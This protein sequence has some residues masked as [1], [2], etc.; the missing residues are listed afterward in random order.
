MSMMTEHLGSGHLQRE[1]AAK[2]LVHTEVEVDTQDH[3]DHTFAGVMFDVKARGAIPIEYLEVKSIYVRGELGP[4]T[5]WITEE[6][7]QG[8]HES[9]EYWTCIHEQTH[10]ASFT[11]LRELPF[12]SPVRL[13]PGQQVGLY[14]H[15]KTEGDSQVVYDNQRQIN[16]ND[17]SR[18]WDE[19]IYVLPGMAHL[20]NV[21]FSR[22]GTEGMHWWG[23]PWRPRREFVGRVS[24]GVRWLL[25]NPDINCTLPPAFREIVWGLMMSRHERASGS[26]LFHLET[27]MLFY[28]LNKVEWWTMGD[29][30][31]PKWRAPGWTNAIDGTVGMQADSSE[32]DSDGSWHPYHYFTHVPVAHLDDDSVEEC[33]EDGDEDEEACVS[34]EE[35]PCDSDELPADCAHMCEAAV[36]K[37]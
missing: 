37:S 36:A 32:E 26:F 17:T 15:S 9:P 28:I 24:Y 14:V 12:H 22:S 7:H 11:E 3:E 2:E 13:L 8:K 19:F 5:V 34:C 33:E 18:A 31:D 1:H 35:D 6:S 4:M 10:P 23:S 20:C 25:W 16:R 21:P 29:K 30:S 27:E